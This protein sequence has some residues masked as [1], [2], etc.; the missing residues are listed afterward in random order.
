LDGRVLVGGQY[1]GV[2]FCVTDREVVTAKHVIRDA[3]DPQQLIFETNGGVSVRVEHVEPARTTDLALLRVA[4]SLAIVAPLAHARRKSEWGVYLGPASF[5]AQLSGVV[6]AID[7]LIH[8]AQ[9]HQQS[10]LQ[11]QVNE[12]LTD[13]R[14]YSGSP[15]IV[16]GAV[17]GVLIE[18]VQERS[19]HPRRATNV[20]YAIPIHVVVQQF[21]LGVP[22]TTPVGAEVQQLLD[23]AFFDLDQIKNT[24]LNARSQTSGKLLGFG[25]ECQ[26]A[27]VVR[28]ICNWLPFYLGRMECKGELSLR[29]DLT[30]TGSAVRAI[31]RYLKSLSHVSVVCPIRVVG[32]PP[33]AIAEFWEALR[34]HFEE[35]SHWLVLLLSSE[36]ID[37]LPDGIV[38]LP[39]PE[40]RRADI[41]TWAQQ[42]V[43]S[44]RWPDA[45]ADVWANLM[46]E[47]SSENGGLDVRF[48]YETLEEAIRRIRTDPEGLRAMLEEEKGETE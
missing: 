40:F 43:A 27:V 24:I 6:T 44:R 48:A 46:I 31:T 21:R 41:S 26:D 28:N 22:I 13:Y 45:L 5:D 9:G 37:V 25:I 18:Q 42:V 10:V 17:V 4:Q 8:D 38:A 11:L 29:A 36:S 47:A 15:I 14:G 20:L 34:V 16:D 35:I 23:T 12:T 19:G 3:S 30:S 1:R 7:H 39:R 33:D 32:A 2:G